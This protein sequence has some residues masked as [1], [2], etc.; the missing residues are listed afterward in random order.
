[1]KNFL[2]EPV[3]INKE[4]SQ[5]YINQVKH[6]LNLVKGV[7]TGSFLLTTLNN[8]GKPIKIIPYSTSAN[9]SKYGD[10]NALASGNSESSLVEFSPVTWNPLAKCMK[11][12]QRNNG[13]LAHEV[14][15]HELVHSF[16]HISGKSGS[17]S[18]GG[19][20]RYM[21]NNEEFYAVTIT[22]VFISD[23]TNRKRSGLRN[24]HLGHSKLRSEFDDR[25]EFYGMGVQTFELIERFFLEHP[26]M[27]YG[28]AASA[29]RAK[30]NPFADYVNDKERCRR[31]SKERGAQV[32][33]RRLVWDIE[34]IFGI[35][36]S[37]F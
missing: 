25:F 35:S 7:R 13:A 10:C 22:N 26:G 33:F 5:T 15:L 1:M 14:L 32:E 17:I 18:L 29:K 6:C 34:K 37:N 31:I 8:Y 24:S 20:L 28:L 36:P 21:A 27:A 4:A 9:L 19:A 12:A 30:F 3:G 23:P 16:R 11:G 2:I